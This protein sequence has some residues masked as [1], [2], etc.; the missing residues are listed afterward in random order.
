[1]DPFGGPLFLMDS[2]KATKRDYYRKNKYVAAFFHMEKTGGS[3]IKKALEPHHNIL[4]FQ[5]SNLDHYHPQ[6]FV[7]KNGWDYF[8]SLG[9]VFASV[10]NP[11]TRLASFYRYCQRNESHPWHNIATNIDFLAFLKF[12]GNQAGFQHTYLRYGGR[13]L[14]TRWVRFESLEQDLTAIGDEL[15]ITFSLPQYN[16]NPSPDYDQLLTPEVKEYIKTTW[17]KDFEVFGY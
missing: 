14:I 7:A 16:V 12:R 2:M 6:H 11:Y 1:M 4:Y 8:S 3:S 5:G 13:D 9:I 17:A 15:G 10:R